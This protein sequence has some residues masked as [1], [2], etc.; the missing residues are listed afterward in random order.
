MTDSI[1]D[2]LSSEAK[3]LASNK[4][5][6]FYLDFQKYHTIS[7]TFFFTNHLVD[8][9]KKDVLPF[10]EQKQAPGI[11][12]A[13]KVS[14]DAG[15]LILIEGRGWDPAQIKQWSLLAQLAGLMHDMHAPDPDH[16]SLGAATARQIL[17][18]YPLLDAEKEAIVSAIRHHDNVSEK[19]CAR[20]SLCGWVSNALHDADKFRW[21]LDN[22]RASLFATTLKEKHDSVLD[23][24]IQLP[25]KLKKIRSAASTFKTV[26]GQRYGF[27]FINAGLAIGEHLHQRLYDHITPD[28]A[29]THPSHSDHSL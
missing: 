21:S 5:I 17:A 25:E 3:N 14:I 7:E 12:H 2:E 13:K 27:Q 20:P 8:R 23:I 24:W 26:T 10:L 28:K 29:R 6:E 15:T 18:G 1:L 16:A 9:C 22:L 4:R 11:E 19:T